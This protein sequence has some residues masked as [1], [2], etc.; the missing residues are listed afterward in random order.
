MKRIGL[1]GGSFDPVH[2]AHV[3][4]AR[5]ALEELRLSQVELI[6]AAAPWQRGPLRATPAQRCDMIRLA[7][8]DEPGIVL[9]TAEIDRGG[10]TYTVDTVRDLPTEAGG[11]RRYVWLLGADQLANF[12]TWRE[13]QTIADRVDL[14]VATRPGTPLTP[15]AA[16]Q[17]HLAAQGRHVEILP[18][19]EMAVSA[20][21]IRDRLAHDL[22]VDG[23]LAEP[24]Y[25]YIRAHRLYHG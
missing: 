15:P 18:F 22:P 17:Q 2:L 8:A 11:G 12:C 20:S 6:P 16:L 24:V 13:W 14:A 9:N 1:L 23:L 25:Q 3:A 21:A 4:L 10:P 5:A 7:I 19:A